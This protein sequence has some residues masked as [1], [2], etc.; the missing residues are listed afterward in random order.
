MSF[1]RIIVITT[2]KIALANGA[3][4]C[5]AAI[6][7][8]L[9]GRTRLDA[10]KICVICHLGRL[11]HKIIC[12]ICLRI[13]RKNTMSIDAANVAKSFMAAIRGVRAVIGGCKRRD[14]TFSDVA[15]F[16]A[17]AIT[18]AWHAGAV[19]H[20]ACVIIGCVIVWQGCILQ[21]TRH[22]IFALPGLDTRGL[23]TRASRDVRTSRPA[24]AASKYADVS[25]AGP[26]ETGKLGL[27]AG[28]GVHLGR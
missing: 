21:V 7:G 20:S 10:R 8:D 2:N 19:L 16:F 18:I 9:A 13:V 3:R 12:V 27:V 26:G 25:V 5:I 15:A 23:D 24:A 1:L 4:A 17:S 6:R 11:T 22:G 28:T 14:A